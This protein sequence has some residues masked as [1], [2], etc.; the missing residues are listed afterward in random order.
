MSLDQHRRY[1]ISG[2]LMESKEEAK[3]CLMNMKVFSYREHLSTGSQNSD[4]YN[5][6]GW[7]CM[8]RSGQMLLYNLLLRH[9]LEG[10]QLLCP[11]IDKQEKKRDA[12]FM[13][14]VLIQY[15]DFYNKDAPFS[16][17]NLFERGSRKFNLE[18]GEF[19]DSPKF[20]AV[21]SESLSN[22]NRNS[23]LVDV[24]FLA[25]R[26]GKEHVRFA[27]NVQETAESLRVLSVLDGVVS[28]SRVRTLFKVHPDTVLVMPF[29]LRLG[30]QKVDP[31]YESFLFA[32]ISLP[33]FVGMLGGKKK[34]AFYIFGKSSKTNQSG[35]VLGGSKLLYLDPH[36]VQNVEGG[37]GLTGRCTRLRTSAPSAFRT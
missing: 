24:N 21:V 12:G 9:S 18:S 2:K 27:L 3:T 16:F 36:F 4:L 5:D 13:F 32:L 31:R 35:E 28:P 14:R 22:L 37:A 30:K 15:F 20:F 19:W 25:R 23:F 1:V 7:G 17:K 33:W 26:N 29:V 11:S 8:L 10:V 34:K 6:R